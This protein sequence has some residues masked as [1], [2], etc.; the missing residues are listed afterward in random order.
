MDGFG[1]DNQRH[2]LGTKGPSLWPPY[3]AP[4]LLLYHPSVPSLTRGPHKG[5]CRDFWASYRPHQGHGEEALSPLRGWGA[6]STVLCPHAGLPWWLSGKKFT[7]QCRRLRF[8]SWVG[9][10]PQRREWL[11]TP[12]FSPGRSHGQRSL[13]GCSP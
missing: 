9:K 4:R 1:S 7:C 5:A 13:V 2:L 11:P 10:I 12:V 8:D 3:P 6:D